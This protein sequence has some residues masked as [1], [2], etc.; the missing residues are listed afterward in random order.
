MGESGLPGELFALAL[1]QM[2]L[3]FVSPFL[4]AIIYVREPFQVK[5]S[6]LCTFLQRTWGT[7]CCGFPEGHKLV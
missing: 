5:G 4:K 1:A 6:Q 7:D 3:M 2:A